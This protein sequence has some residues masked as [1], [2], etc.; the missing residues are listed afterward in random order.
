MPPSLYLDYNATTPVDPAVLEAMLPWFSADF[1][2]AG[3]RTHA[4]GWRAEQAVKQ[5]REQLRSSLNASTGEIVFTSGATEALN[6]AIK[7]LAAS[8][9]HK[10]KHVL[11]WQTEHRA[12][13]DPCLWLRKQGFDVEVLP[14]LPFGQ[15]D[16]M[17]YQAALQPDTLLVCG[18]LANNETGSIF[19]IG[20][21]AAMAHDAGAFFLCDA[22]Q[23][24]GKIAV[25]VEALGID[26]LVCSAHKFYGPKGTGA[27]WM[28]KK[29][30]L[31]PQALLHGGGQEN[32]W[33]SGTLNVPGIVGMGAAAALS[34]QLL[35]TEMARQQRMQIKFEG[36]LLQHLPEITIQGKDAARLPNTS[37]I[38]LKH[39]PAASLIKHLRNLALSTGSAC[40]SHKA[41]ASH[42]LLALGLNEAEAA[43][44]LRI[45]WGRPTSEAA[46]M[47]AAEQMVMAVEQ[48]RAASPA[49]RYRQG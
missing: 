19:P 3:S 47:A 28:A 41:E 14:V 8:W 22:S 46:L 33:R 26:L 45:S 44:C 20:E 31:K 37:N 9:Q 24:V 27:L 18:M 5:A 11:L 12:V 34:E 35:I 30:G 17:A 21:L 38:W 6:L 4:W 1:G 25:D 42:V 10:K 16:I 49:W 48:V 2:N 13:I 43:C 7:G 23:A 15:P 32:G 36:H 40:S 39:A 29:A